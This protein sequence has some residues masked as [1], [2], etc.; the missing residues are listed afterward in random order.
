MATRTPDLRAFCVSIKTSSNFACNWHQRSALCA[1]LADTCCTAAD[2]SA[3]SVRKPRSREFMRATIVSSTHVCIVAWRSAA[4]ALKFAF[5]SVSVSASFL[6]TSVALCAFR[7]CAPCRSSSRRFKLP[8][9][10]PMSCWSRSALS[11][12]APAID[13]P[14]LATAS[15]FSKALWTPASSFQSL[16]ASD[17]MC[18][19]SSTT[20]DLRNSSDCCT[21]S[22]RLL[23]RSAACALRWSRSSAR[24]SRE[25][26]NAPSILL[27]QSSRSTLNCST[28]WLARSVSCATWSRKSLERA[29]WV[30]SARAKDSLCN[31]LSSETCAAERSASAE[32][33]LCISSPSAVCSSLKRTRKSSM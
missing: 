6:S 11:C 3:I 32:D 4:L 27:L 23:W 25:A 5:N 22:A 16:S 20:S 18:S 26:L 28:R 19:R 31:F 24:C 2:R 33:R 15:T 29:L 1:N 21:C 8:L 30:S 14:V 17:A 10:S 13:L 7:P 9:T 12:E